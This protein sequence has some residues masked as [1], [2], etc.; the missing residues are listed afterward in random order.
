MVGMV[1]ACLLTALLGVNPAVVASSAVPSDVGGI[2]S[3]DRGLG[4]CDG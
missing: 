1:T 2:A 3:T 4:C